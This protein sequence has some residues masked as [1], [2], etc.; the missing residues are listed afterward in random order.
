[1]KKEQ[2]KEEQG[3]EMDIYGLKRAWSVSSMMRLLY[4]RMIM[5][6]C[7]GWGGWMCGE[8]RRQEWMNAK[9]RRLNAMD[10]RMEAPSRS[11]I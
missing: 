3:A 11:S 2:K 5:V 8:E 10:R 9:K 6:V 7:G 1:M 4:S